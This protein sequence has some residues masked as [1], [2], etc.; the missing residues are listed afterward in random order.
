MMPTISAMT[1]ALCVIGI[2]L[3]LAVIGNWLLD[4]LGYGS[5][6]NR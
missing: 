4:W 6:D 5:G 1:I 3:V 2:G